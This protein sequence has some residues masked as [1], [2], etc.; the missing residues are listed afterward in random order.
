MEVAWPVDLLGKTFFFRERNL[1][2]QNNC[3]CFNTRFSAIVKKKIWVTPK[4]CLCLCAYDRSVFLEDNDTHNKLMIVPCRFIV[5]IVKKAA[6]C[7]LT[8]PACRLDL[9]KM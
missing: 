7:L 9:E 1:V 2:L 8:L 4:K 3:C 5:R 6:L